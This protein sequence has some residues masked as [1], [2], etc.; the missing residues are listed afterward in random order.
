KVHNSID[1]YNRKKH[2]D[3][4]LRLHKDPKKRMEEFEKEWKR[5]LEED[6]QKQQAIIINE[7][8]DFNLNAS[9]T[10]KQQMF[11]EKY[12]AYLTQRMQMLKSAYPD[13]IE[14]VVQVVARSLKEE[15]LK[16][17]EETKK[18][19]RSQEQELKKKKKKVE[20]STGGDSDAD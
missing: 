1:L 6:I 2:L 11:E 8:M 20:E 16:N 5:I 4:H 10:E 18:Q 3:A 9:P 7:I 13:L 12:R 15:K 14:K 19:L 17:L